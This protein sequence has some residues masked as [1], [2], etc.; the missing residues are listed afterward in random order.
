MNIRSVS[1]KR[2]NELIASLHSLVKHWCVLS[3]RVWIVVRFAS[4]PLASAEKQ[5][6][7]STCGA[8]ST[9]NS[10]AC[11][12]SR[13]CSGFCR[14]LKGSNKLWHRWVCP[15]DPI[16]FHCAFIHCFRFFRMSPPVH[17]PFLFLCEES[18]SSTN[19]VTHHKLKGIVW[20]FDL[21]LAAFLWSVRWGDWSGPHSTGN[22]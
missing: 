20:H 9:A 18:S 1:L 22:M 7:A 3:K 15:H 16:T 14:R 21:C 10:A 13:C 6:R 12:Q 8:Q 17:L 2:W 11:D 19:I 4:R 5:R